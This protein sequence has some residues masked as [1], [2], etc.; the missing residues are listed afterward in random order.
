M[1]HQQRSA[2]FNMQDLDEL[3]GRTQKGLTQTRG[4]DI[5]HLR[6]PTMEIDMPVKTRT[7]DMRALPEAIR[8]KG[9][10]VYAL[11]GGGEFIDN[12]AAVAVA[13]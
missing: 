12:R 11:P 10:L 3:S 13:A 7:H 8:Y 9:A 2:G 1:L 5:P 4:G 6:H